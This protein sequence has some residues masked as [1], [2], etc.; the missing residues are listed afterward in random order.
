MSAAPPALTPAV[1]PAAGS[2][3]GGGPRNLLAAGWTAGVSAGGVALI[4][5]FAIPQGHAPRSRAPQQRK[6][7]RG[8]GGEEGG[9]LS[10]TAD[11]HE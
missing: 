8:G 3:G 4:P 5:F 1:H 9:N 11:R 10:L 7:R 6:A 2:G